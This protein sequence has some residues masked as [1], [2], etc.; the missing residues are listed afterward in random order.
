MLYCKIEMLTIFI[1]FYALVFFFLYI[2]R[3]KSKD[4]YVMFNLFLK[5][6]FNSKLQI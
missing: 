1:S 6:N 5:L 2:S 4:L 3:L